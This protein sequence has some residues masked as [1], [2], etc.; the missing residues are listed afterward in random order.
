MGCLPLLIVPA[1]LVAEYYAIVWVAAQ[2][3]WGFTL[4]GLLAPMAF[5]GLLVRTAGLAAALHVRDALQRGEAP[6][7]TLFDGA[8]LL[9]AGSLFAF[10]GFLTDVLALLL[11][12]PPVRWLLFAWIGGRVS[13]LRRAPGSPGMGSAR[14]GGPGGPNVFVWTAQGRYT[15]G[16]AAAPRQSHQPG[17]VIDAEWTEVG[18]KNS[19]SRKEIP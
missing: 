9:A 3:G 11:L 12:L 2:V 18:E 4:L 14:T 19:D 1:M 5:G 16:P 15:A 8:C 13:R 6:G 7:R 10:P 17:E